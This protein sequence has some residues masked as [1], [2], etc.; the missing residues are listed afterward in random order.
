MAQNAFDV[1]GRRLWNSLGDHESPIGH[2]R[3]PCPRMFPSNSQ[4]LATTKTI[5]PSSTAITSA[6]D[7]SGADFG[8]SGKTMYNTVSIPRPGRPTIRNGS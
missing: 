6:R 3:I 2:S 7:K 8:V 4:A 1:R 5:V